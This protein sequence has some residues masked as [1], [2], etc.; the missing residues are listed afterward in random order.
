LVENTANASHNANNEPVRFA[1]TNGTSYTAT[2]Y[3]KDAGRQYLQL[4]FGSVEFGA[5][6]YATFD[7]VGGTVAGSAAGTAT[8][9]AVGGG[10]YRCAFTATA[11]STA[12]TAS[13][14]FILSNVTTGRGPTYT[15][16][17]TSGIYIWGAQL[18]NSAS[19]DPYVYNP[20]A[21]PTSTAYYGPRFDYNPTGT[22]VTSGVELVNISA[23]P[24]P[25][26][27]NS[28]GSNGV[29]TASTRTM[30]NTAT[31]SNTE[32]PRFAFNFGLVT[33][34][35]YR[36]QGR[37]TGNTTS[38]QRPR[39]ATSGTANDI[40]YNSATGVFS[41]VVAANG[42]SLEFLMNGTATA[43]QALV[44]EE[45]SIQAVTGY[46]ATANG[47]LIEEQRTNLLTYSDQLNVAPSAKT[48][49]TVADNAAVSPSGATTASK[50]S[51]TAVSNIH[52]LQLTQATSALTYTFSVYVKAAEYSWCQIAVFDNTNS[53]SAFVNLA[54]GALGTTSGTATF[55][56]TSSGNGW[57][58]VT[59]TAA[60]LASATS[61]FQIWVA[62][63]NNT[64][65]FLGDGT[66]G[67]LAYG[68]QLE[69]G[70][71]ATSYIPTVASQVT[72][73]AD[74]ASMLGDNFAT[75]Y[76]QTQGT[77][78]IQATPNAVPAD[79]RFAS[80][81]DGT[82]TNRI[83]IW[84]SSSSS[85]VRYEVISGGANQ[86]ALVSSGTLI[87]KSTFKAAATYAL[88]DFAFSV[89]GGAVL[90]DNVGV[91]PVVVKALAIGGSSTAVFGSNLIRSISYYPVALPTS[92]QSITS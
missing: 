64:S 33:N 51:A 24:T 71:F 76:N 45:M 83:M 59:I 23:L 56:V 12:A 21:A 68:A 35:I 78:V 5:T 90:T 66:S 55:G 87:S 48:N 39:L 54:T 32:F 86:V 80:L 52:V 27:A 73:A 49:V 6:Q 77:L 72:R 81:D 62:T 53:F 89:N 14:F 9:V 10:W 44:I 18:S 65:S 82:S 63:A 91:L 13:L 26:I 92:I 17:G 15:G 16:D 31:G 42:S 79:V 84:G 43:P 28:G 20:Q 75:W 61:Y 25:T 2:V 38:L 67:I 11:T 70:S 22:P 74:N 7:L 69:A 34:T 37:L 41:A 88:N 47:L 50:I 40:A 1:S 60:L 57:W 8:I 4:S 46:T 3:A 19:V 85:A 30:S 36:V 29:W 58:R